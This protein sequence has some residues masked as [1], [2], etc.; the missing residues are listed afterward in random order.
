M[1]RTKYKLILLIMLF[2][3]PVAE[4]DNKSDIYEAYIN[5]NMSG[6]KN[7]ID[8][9][10]NAKSKNNLF[11][12]EL[13]NYQYGYIAWCLGNKRFDEGRKY[14]DSADKNIAM[15]SSDHR[16]VSIVNAYKAAFYGFRIALNK[17]KAPFLGPKSIDCAKKA[18]ELDG[19]NPF[20]Y[21]Q[22]GNIQFY[23]P[24]VFGGSKKEALIYF[25]RALTLM[26]KSP[27]GLHND[28]NYI[29]LL[30]LI[31]QSY[32]YTGDHQSSVKYLE[33]IMKIEPR[34]Q[35]IKNELYPQILNKMK[36]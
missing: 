2:V 31:A 12:L 5:S 30:M 18:I 23:M 36:H 1:E 19:Q 20:G 4:A 9:M 16:Y 29:N 33:K 34:F 6:W 32:S 26:E 15:L 8:R 7:I 28:W 25:S 11:L 10:E 17:I 13:V 24:P 35:Y 27:A 3:N 21:I 14:L 22:Y